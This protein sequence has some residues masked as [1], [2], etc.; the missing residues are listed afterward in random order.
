[1]TGAAVRLPE[2]SIRGSGGAEFERRGGRLQD[3]VPG[4]VNAQVAVSVDPRGGD[5]GAVVFIEVPAGERPDPAVGPNQLR[6][7]K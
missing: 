4:V 1:M 7:A 6:R 2:A 5:V 3:P